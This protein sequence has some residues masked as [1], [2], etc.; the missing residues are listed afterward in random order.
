[1]WYNSAMSPYEHIVDAV[2]G[3]SQEE[4]FKLRLL[5]DQDL[6]QAPVNDGQNARPSFIGLLADEPELADQIL[7]SAMVARETRQRR[8]PSE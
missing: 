5:L 8:M 7:E 2:H 3:L 1:M 6:K 4:K